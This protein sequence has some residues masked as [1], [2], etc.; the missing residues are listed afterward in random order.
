MDS[1]RQF[2]DCEEFDLPLNAHG[3][4]SG[5]VDPSVYGRG[6]HAAYIAMAEADFSSH[7]AL[8]HFVLGGVF[9]RHPGL[10]LV[11]TEQAMGIV[12]QVVDV[13]YVRDI[14][15]QK[16]DEPDQVAKIKAAIMDR[17]PNL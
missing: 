11:F 6:P 1:E 4:F 16:I 13:F 7:R 2:N 14:N 9:D 15:G 17:L 8:A 5:Y 10:K 3:G 12:D